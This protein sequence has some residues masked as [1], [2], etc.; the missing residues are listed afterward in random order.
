MNR[1]GTVI[2]PP[3]HWKPPTSDL[4][5]FG[6][7]QEQLMWTQVSKQLIW[8]AMQLLELET[9]LLDSEDVL[10]SGNAHC[11]NAGAMSRRC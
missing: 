11:D 3:L 5:D 9:L 6:F 7:A 4:G 1:D 8:R 10:S 2:G